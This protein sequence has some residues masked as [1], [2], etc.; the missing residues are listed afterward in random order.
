VSARLAPSLYERELQGTGGRV[1]LC[2]KYRIPHVT[3][4]EKGG[5]GIQPRMTDVTDARDH[6][7]DQSPGTT[8]K[9]IDNGNLKN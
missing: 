7:Y 8:V 9:K 1:P 4:L 2:A 5:A 6:Q 3:W